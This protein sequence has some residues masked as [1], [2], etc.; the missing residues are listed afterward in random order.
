MFR[1]INKAVA[2]AMCVAGVAAAVGATP[3]LAIVT[4]IGAPPG[5][6]KSQN[7]IFDQVY[8]G[9]F[10]PSGVNFIGSAGINATRID[11][12]S[13]QLWGGQFVGYDVKARFAAYTQE[14][15]YFAGI[16]GGS[17]TKIFDVSGTGY[18]VSEAVFVDPVFTQASVM[19][20]ART[21]DQGGTWSSLQ[22]DNPGGNK[23]HMVTYQIT[24]LTGSPYDGREVYM[25]FWED[26][27]AGDW[28]YNDLAVELV[29]VTPPPGGGNQTEPTPEPVTASLGALGTA[30]LLMAATRRR[31]RA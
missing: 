9:T 30:G 24:G 31:G 10:S 6:E 25:V 4:P 18:S 5:G 27:N 2:S 26:L 11:D 22:S 14:F 8:P 12:A 15:G 23:D 19:R 1:K 20:W 7:E 16:S 3:A 28:D 13:D 17:F 29:R 21:G